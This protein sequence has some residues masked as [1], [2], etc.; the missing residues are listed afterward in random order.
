MSSSRVLIG[1]MC[2]RSIRDGVGVVELP[3]IFTPADRPE[4]PFK[5]LAGG[6]GFE[7]RFSE[8]ESDVLPLNYPPIAE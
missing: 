2:G 8:S 3:K 4:A 1:V 7:P 5:V 6:L